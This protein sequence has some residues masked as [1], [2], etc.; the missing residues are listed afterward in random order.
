MLVLVGEPKRKTY[1]VLLNNRLNLL[2]YILHL[3]LEAWVDEMDIHTI[4]PLMRFIILGH[5]IT[6]DK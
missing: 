4:A 5:E 2:G 1:F 3:Q 6:P